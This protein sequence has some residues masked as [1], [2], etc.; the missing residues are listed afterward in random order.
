MLGVK[1]VW[2]MKKGVDIERKSVYT[3]FNNASK[4]YKHA[5]RET[6]IKYL[7]ARRKSP[8]VLFL[9]PFPL[10]RKSAPWTTD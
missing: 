1:T 2:C 4:K 7:P 5:S 9:Y 6:T 10:E 3:D 8:R